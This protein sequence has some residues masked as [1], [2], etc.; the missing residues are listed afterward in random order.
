MLMA[1]WFW[2]FLCYSFLGFLFEV[3]FARATRN[4]KR[5][6]KCRYFLPICPVY[7]LGAVAVLLLPESV[8]ARPVL[9]FLCAAVLCTAVEYLTGL[10]YEKAAGVAFW[11]YA[12]LPL[13]LN[14]R[15][16][17]LFSLIWGVLSLLLLHLTQPAV[18]RLAQA[19]PLWLLPPALLFF[20][21]D[22]GITLFVL[23]ATRDT[24]ALRWYARLRRPAPDSRSPS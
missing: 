14:G 2:Y 18:E 3:A 13:N 5:D 7:G 19:A 8:R 12:H 9:F 11:D 4:P 15:V 16:C 22:S 23:R 10:F 6:R 1:I 20:L 17:L 24:G 21:L